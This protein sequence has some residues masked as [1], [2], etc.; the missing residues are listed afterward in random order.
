M[1]IAINGGR[2]TKPVTQ[3]EL[4]GDGNECH[5]PDCQGEHMLGPNCHPDRPVVAT[6]NDHSGV[7]RLLCSV[8]GGGVA[9]ILVAARRPD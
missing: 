5:H 9:A 4:K 7:L 8:C 6:Y 3:A 2:P 1:S